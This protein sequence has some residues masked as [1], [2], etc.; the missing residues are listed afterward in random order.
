[1]QLVRFC[2][3]VCEDKHHNNTDTLMTSLFLASPSKNISHLP[4]E[5]HQHPAGDEE[6]K[7]L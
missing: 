7:V 3:V 4:A 1:M 6:Q 2:W 5:P